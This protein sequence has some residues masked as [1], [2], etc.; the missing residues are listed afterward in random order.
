MHSRGYK[1]KRPIFSVLFFS[2]CAYV[3][4]LKLRSVPKYSNP[5]FARAYVCMCDVCICVCACIKCGKV[6]P[7]DINASGDFSC[8]LHKNRKNTTIKKT[9]FI[10]VQNETL[11]IK[12]EKKILVIFSIHIYSKNIFSHLHILIDMFSHMVFDIHP[13]EMFATR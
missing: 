12:I 4:L 5:I 1:F 3:I 11:R 9:C 2:L 6:K 10:F 8:R 13:F 7:T